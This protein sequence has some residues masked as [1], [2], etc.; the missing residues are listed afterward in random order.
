MTNP[1]GARTRMSKV[2]SGLVFSGGNGIV[3]GNTP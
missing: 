2:K 1:L 3:E